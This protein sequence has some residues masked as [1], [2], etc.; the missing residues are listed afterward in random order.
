MSN[1]VLALDQGTSSSRAVL[2]DG[3][4]GVVGMAQN[5]FRQIFPRPGWVEHDPRDIWNSQLSAARQ[6][7]DAHGVAASKIAAIGIANQRE[8]SVLWD[9]AT[10]Q[11]LMNA[12]VWQ[13]RRTADHCA[14]LCEQG[15]QELVREKTGLVIDA[16]F[17]ATKLKWMLDHIP[18]ARQRAARGELAFGT[19][20]SW[21]VY[22]LSGAH[23]TDASNASRTMLFNITTM[24]W[25]RRLLELFDIP[26][27]VLPEVVSSSGVIAHTLP[28]LLGGAVP[29]AGL[30]GDQQAATFGQACHAPGM[31][32]NTI[33][34]GSFMLMNVGGRPAPS[35]HRLLSTVGWSRGSEVTHLMEGSAFMAGAT[36]QWLR[37][38]LG[39]VDDVAQVE[40]LAGTVGD[41]DGVVLVPAFS[42]LGA[43]H[44]DPYAR[45]AILGLHRGSTKAHIARA[46]L[47][48]IAYQTVDVL[49]AMEADA[50]VKL[51]ELRVDGGGAK[52]DLLMQLMADALGV[53][54]VRPANIETTALGAA[55]LAGLGVGLWDSPA[56]LAGLWRAQHR[57][58]P[59]ISDDQR[60]ERILRWREA[61]R[62]SMAWEKC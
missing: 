55:Q 28:E 16:Y 62:R 54:V 51:S 38:G 41:A 47:E 22:K 43:P 15:L 44:W 5:A 48:G 18:G 19:I 8:T 35:R 6:V 2:F 29:I 50:G 23:V 42:G 12:I 36:L 25:D 32:K 57:F 30:A 52:N 58:A 21:L 46:A 61:V 1:Y 24:Q 4:C 27:S 9:R 40:R 26:A 17:S 60:A 10:S 33:G 45:G 56:E 3:E 53:P 20:D 31:A 49:L 13:D 14:S 59:S 39:I 7:L 11:P 34:T 37:E